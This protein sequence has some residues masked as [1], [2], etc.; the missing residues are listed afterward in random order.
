MEATIIY[1][2]DK[3]KEYI[4]LIES[5]FPIFINYI[6]STTFKGKKESFKVKSHWG[7]IK[8]PFVL[9]KDNE[10]KVIKVFYSDAKGSNAIQQFIDY[11]CK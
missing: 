10:D 3:D 1:N 4:N 5:K 7:A 2:D 9:L 6:D 8:N 11:L